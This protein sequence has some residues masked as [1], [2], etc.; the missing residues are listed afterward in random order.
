M[1]SILLN[2]IIGAV[3]YLNVAEFP[4]THIGSVNAIMVLNLIEDKTSANNQE[5]RSLKSIGLWLTGIAF[6]VE[7]TLT[8]PWLVVTMGTDVSDMYIQ[9]YI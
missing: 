7:I 5:V 1:Y 6:R 9:W 3:A 8:P 4:Y 2:D